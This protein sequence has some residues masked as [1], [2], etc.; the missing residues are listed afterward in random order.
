[1]RSQRFACSGALAIAG[2]PLLADPLSLPSSARFKLLKDTRQID[3][4]SFLVPKQTKAPVDGVRIR[5]AFSE[6]RS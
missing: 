4:P 1:M 3:K 5:I 2:W 6:E